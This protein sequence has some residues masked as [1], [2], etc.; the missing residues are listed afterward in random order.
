[1]GKRDERRG[2][3]KGRHGNT[4]RSLRRDVTAFQPL[5][6]RRHKRIEQ[7]V[8][9]QVWAETAAAQAVASPPSPLRKRTPGKKGVADASKWTPEKQAA[10]VTAMVEADYDWH[11]VT[12]KRKQRNAPLQL[13]P[14][15]REVGDG[16]VVTDC[17]AVDLH[18]PSPL[19]TD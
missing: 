7:C 9:R 3:D 15:A 13:E 5:P 8:E 1:M 18:R 4:A 16:S 14:Q 10:R 2:Y 12:S 6:T 19:E 17:G 11:V